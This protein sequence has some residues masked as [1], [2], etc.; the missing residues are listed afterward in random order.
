MGKETQRNKF[1]DF[2]AWPTLL[3]CG[4]AVAAQ[5]GDWGARF[6]FQIFKEGHPSAMMLILKE[7]SINLHTIEWNEKM[8][9]KLRIIY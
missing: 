7:S 8:L 2:M 3:S 4:S 6:I 5:R 1:W 9:N